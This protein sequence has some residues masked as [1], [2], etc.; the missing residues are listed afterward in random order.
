MS[1]MYCEDCKTEKPKNKSLIC[2]KCSY[3]YRNKNHIISDSGKKSMSNARKKEL[4]IIKSP[5]LSK[6]EISS[7][8]LSINIEEYKDS[9][10]LRTF[11]K[12]YPIIFKHILYYAKDYIFSFYGKLLTLRDGEYKCFC[13]HLSTY[14]NKNKKFNEISKCCSKIW[15]KH[16]SKSHLI[17][18]NGPVQGFIKYN[19]TRLNG[20]YK[21]QRNLLWYKNK[22]GDIEGVKKYN[23]IYTKIIN[24]RKTAK[25]SKISQEL[26]NKINFY[27]SD[28]L[29]KAGKLQ[30]ATNGYGEHRIN[31]N[32][33]DKELIGESRITMFVDFKI[34]DKVI[35]FDGD[36]W[37]KNSEEDI[38]RDRILN[39]RQYEVL[40]ISERNYKNNPNKELEKCLK[41]LKLL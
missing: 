17:L 18:K 28:E 12:R 19:E 40:R 24:N 23:E 15:F 8:L 32:K 41:F 11:A 7:I 5:I 37:H 27:I 26:F 9:R 10:K 30:Y 38:I 6:L 36:Y 2:A 33:K 14:D 13:G 22:Y 39:A 34:F 31:F 16:T 25:Y 21:G 4:E 29:A 20:R 1:K 35:E 3:K